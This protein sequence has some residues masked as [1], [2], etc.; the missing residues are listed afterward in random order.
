MYCLIVVCGEEE[1]DM[2]MHPIVLIIYHGILFFRQVCRIH[3]LPWQVDKTAYEDHSQIKFCFFFLFS[4]SYQSKF[5]SSMYS[6]TIYLLCDKFISCTK[7]KIRNHVK[8]GMLVLDGCLQVRDFNPYDCYYYL[9][10]LSL[11]HLFQVSKQ[12]MWCSYGTLYTYGNGMAQFQ[13]PLSLLVTQ[14]KRAR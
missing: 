7:Q 8:W 11:I 10:L 9:L 3:Q 5:Q 6:L 14:T 13:N 4:F 1:I 2:K 12:S